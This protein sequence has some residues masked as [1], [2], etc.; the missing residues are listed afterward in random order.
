V[1]TAIALPRTSHPRRPVNDRDV[2]VELD[3]RMEGH[4][5]GKRTALAL[6]VDYSHLR[7]MRAGSEPVTMKVAAGLGFELRWTKRPK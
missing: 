6:D 1:E 5:N 7:S 4:G 2:L 3:R